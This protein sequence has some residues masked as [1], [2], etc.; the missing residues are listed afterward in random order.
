VIDFLSQ[1]HDMSSLRRLG[2]IEERTMQL[3]LK[4]I[5]LETETHSTSETLMRL[6]QYQGRQHEVPITTSVPPTRPTSPRQQLRVDPPSVQKNTL[7][8]LGGNDEEEDFEDPM[9]VAVV[10]SDAYRHKIAAVTSHAYQSTDA[11]EVGHADFTAAPLP[12]SSPRKNAA[13]A[14]L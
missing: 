9:G 10:H 3:I 13:I 1:N 14:L 2:E 12:V 8:V 4:K 5:L 7:S 6:R 11:V